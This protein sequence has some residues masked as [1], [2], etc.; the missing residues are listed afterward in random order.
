MNGFANGFTALIEERLPVGP[1][2]RR[3]IG[4]RQQQA[5]DALD[6]IIHVAEAA[7]LL[8]G[9]EHSQRLAAQGLYDEVR[10]DPP[11][12]WPHPR[13]VRVEDADDP[14]VQS[15]IAVVGHRHGFRETLGLVVDAAR[16]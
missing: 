15:V 11:V 8:A 9:P 2:L 6:Q 10:D 5:R 4:W 1:L 13:P 14:R 7:G 16:T 3:A 12:L